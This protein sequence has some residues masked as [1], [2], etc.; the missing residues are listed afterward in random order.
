MPSPP[1]LTKKAT[2]KAILWLVMELTKYGIMQKVMK[3]FKKQKLD[4]KY[5]KEI[6]EWKKLVREEKFSKKLD[7]QMK[8]EID[9]FINSR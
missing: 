4:I 5:K 2:A 6:E 8:D 3:E 7:K 9:R 1:G